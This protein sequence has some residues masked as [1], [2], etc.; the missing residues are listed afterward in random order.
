MDKKTQA[1]TRKNSSMHLFPV[2]KYLQP[3]KNV[4]GKGAPR[5]RGSNVSSINS[6]HNHQLGIRLTTQDSKYLCTNK[7]GQVVHT[8]ATEMMPYFC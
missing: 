8:D 1:Q 4:Q 5:E 3:C 7:Q 6:A 2:I